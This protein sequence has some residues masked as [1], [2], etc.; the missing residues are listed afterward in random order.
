MCSSNDY[1]S[2]TRATRARAATR[3]Y[4]MLM[5]G[6]DPVTLPLMKIEENPASFYTQGTRCFCLIRQVSERYKSF[7]ARQ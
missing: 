1:L 6:E 7:Y 4:F 2:S 5:L 3:G